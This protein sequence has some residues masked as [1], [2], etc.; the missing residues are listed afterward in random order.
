MNL[1][2]ISVLAHVVLC[3]LR[4]RKVTLNEMCASNTFASG[5]YTLAKEFESSNMEIES[6][7]W[8]LGIEVDQV[9]AHV[10]LKQITD[11]CE[12]LQ[13]YEE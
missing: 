11:M 13:M 6:F 4:E 12:E 1:K 9:K 7:L 8:G 3:S 5:I 2:E 10:G